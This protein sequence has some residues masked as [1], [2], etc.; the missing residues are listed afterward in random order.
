[1]WF[2]WI[3][4]F[5]ALCIIGI[6]IILIGHTIWLVTKRNEKIFEMENKKMEEE[7]NE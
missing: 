4:I 2:I 5:M 7:E 1:M 3:L 6:V